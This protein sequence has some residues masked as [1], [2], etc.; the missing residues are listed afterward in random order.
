MERSI[1]LAVAIPE[2]VLSMPGKLDGR[3]TKPD[4]FYPSL[5]MFLDNSFR[6]VVDRLS[7]PGELLSVALGQSAD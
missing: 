6:N 3:E 5:R 2:F 1:A 4:V 7:I